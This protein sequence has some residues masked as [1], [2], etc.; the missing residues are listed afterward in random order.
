M[1]VLSLSHCTLTPG[2]PRLTVDAGNDNLAIGIDHTI[3]GGIDFS[4]CEATVTISDSIVDASQASP[5][6]ALKCYN[7]EIDG[8][9]VF[10]LVNV[11]LI[12]ASNSIFTDVVTSRRRQ[13]GCIRFCFVPF[14]SKVPRQFRC[15]PA[16]YL[17]N[18]SGAM[19]NQKNILALNVWPNC[20][21][22]SLKYGDAGYA[23]LFK[24]GPD[25]S[26][27]EQMMQMKWEFLMSFNKR[28]A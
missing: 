27:K 8:S 18:F 2:K 25:R 6:I 12:N 23:Q 17:G 28:L 4:A 15:Q 22:T 9:T 16:L 13:V 19:N 3:T 14:G 5:S 26:F 20:R 10:G 21:F 7:V 11:V 24:D 1:G